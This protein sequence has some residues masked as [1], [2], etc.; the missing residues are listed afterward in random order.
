MAYRAAPDVSGFSNFLVTKQIKMRSVGLTREELDEHVVR[1]RRL[2]E[3]QHTDKDKRGKF[4]L[5]DWIG[6]VPFHV[7]VSEYS[8]GYWPGTS[9]SMDMY[10]LRYHGVTL[11]G[12]PIPTY[13]IRELGGISR[14]S[15]LILTAALEALLNEF[16]NIYNN[17]AIDPVVRDMRAM[18]EIEKGGL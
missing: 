17:E 7:L 6:D 15:R 18:L 14:V 2:W 4:V 13:M 16:K 1:V 9:V 12:I 10:L 3:A 8:E 11:G 5:V